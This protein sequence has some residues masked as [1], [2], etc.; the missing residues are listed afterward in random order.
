MC[1]DLFALWLGKKEQEKQKQEY[2][3]AK[4]PIWFITVDVRVE[5]KQMWEQQPVGPVAPRGSLGLIK[6]LLTLNPGCHS[7]LVVC[8]CSCGTVDFL[9]S[10]LASTNTLF[11]TCNSRN[12]VI[13]LGPNGCKMN[14]RSD[15]SVLDLD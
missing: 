15:Y 11:V 5:I 3:T 4:H 1:G 13:V 9:S 6:C 10:R 14:D 12:I 8:V 2:E 7:G